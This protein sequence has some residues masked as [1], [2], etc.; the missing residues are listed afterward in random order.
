MLRT[1]DDTRAADAVSE[2]F[3]IAAEP[4]P[5]GLLLR[6]ADGAGLVPRL[7]TGPGLTVHS[8]SV[9]PPTLDDVFLHHTG[10]A[11]RETGTNAHT[12]S[13]IGEGLR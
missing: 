5:D 2:R 6:V 1:E 4:T 11:I 3:G 8:V 13:N 12:L 9:A 7:C 10:S